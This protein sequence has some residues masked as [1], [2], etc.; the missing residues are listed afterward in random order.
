MYGVGVF[1]SAF[2]HQVSSLTN[3][4]FILMRRDECELAQFN[5]ALD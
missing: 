2:G 3:A 5:S 1:N 4:F